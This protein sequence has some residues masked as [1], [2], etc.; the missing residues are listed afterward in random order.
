MTSSFGLG[1]YAAGSAKLQKRFSHGLSFQSAYVWSHAL[2]DGNTPLS[3]DTSILNQ[4]NY[5]A[6][7]ASASW[8]IRHNFTTGFNFE[9]PFGRG[10]HFG[11]NMNRFADL[12][13][14]GW[15][16][17]GSLTL[18]TGDAFTM[19]GTSCHG[20]WSKCMP[21]YVAGYSGSGNAAP[22]GGRTDNEYFNTA[23]YTVAYSNQALGIATGGNVGLQTLTGPPTKT[24]DFS[25]FKIFKLTERVGVQFRG[26]AINLGNFAVLNNPDASLGDSK[27]F[28]G[29]GN[30]GLITSS[31]AGT[32]RHLQFSLRMTF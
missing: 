1:R 11:G 17:N 13:A 3:G 29:N 20:V 28:G 8:D 10:K 5:T 12:I 9:L 24:L 15:Q 14:G 27:A 4:T 23:N 31:V 2:A 21:D 30:F 16:T 32:E 19:S 25:I 6:S 22:P 26:E 7:Y 18:R